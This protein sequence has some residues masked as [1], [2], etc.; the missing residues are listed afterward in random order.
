[1]LLHYYLYPEHAPTIRADRKALPFMLN[2]WIIE[3]IRKREQ[4]QRQDQ[5]RPRAEL[6]I[7][8]PQYHDSP[9]QPAVTPPPSER[10]VVIMDI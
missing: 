10:G 4:E 3:E 7:E 5:E 6:P 8:G 1:M 9:F 2:P